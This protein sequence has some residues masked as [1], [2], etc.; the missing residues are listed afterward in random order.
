[1]KLPS[2]KLILLLY[3]TVYAS[4]LMAAKV[5]IFPQASKLK[6]TGHYSK[7]NY[8]YYR[9]IDENSNVDEALYQLSDSLYKSGNVNKALEYLSF[10]LKKVPTHE[11][12]L[13]LRSRIHIHQKHYSEALGDVEQL[14][15]YNPSP[16]VYM[17]LDSVHTAMGNKI[18]AQKA[19]KLYEVTIS[20]KQD[21]V[22]DN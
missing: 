19:R 11:Q 10:L 20:G 21:G 9:A 8:Y 4:S 13:L 2:I 22:R 1:M 16:D 17:L 14:E 3:A 6:A 7:A 15:K 18:S 5:D 12:G